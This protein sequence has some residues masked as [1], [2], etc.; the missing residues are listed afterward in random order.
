MNAFLLLLLLLPSAGLLAAGGTLAGRVLAQGEPLGGA[1]VVLVGE[2]KGAATDLNGG[3]LILDV[4]PGPHLLRVSYLGMHTWEQD[5]FMLSEYTTRIDVELMPQALQGDTLVVQARR[6]LSPLDATSSQAVL[7]RRE[8]ELS[9]RSDFLDLLATQAGVTRDEDGGMHLRGGRLGEVRVLLD[10]QDL[11]DPLDM[12]FQDLINEDM[13][14]ELVVVSGT[15]GAR[16]GDALSGVVR[17]TGQSRVRR[18]E[19]RL[20]YTSADLVDSPWRERGAY[21]VPE[22]GLWRET[23]HGDLFG[24]DPAWGRLNQPGRM[25]LKVAT[26]ARMSGVDMVLGL[27]S[28][29]QDSHLPHGGSSRGDLSLNLGHDMASGGRLELGLGRK[30]SL[31]QGYSHFWKYLPLNRHS[32]LREQQRLNLRFSNSLGDRSVYRL[33]LGLV[34]NE[35][36]RGILRD[37]EWLAES[38]YRRRSFSAQQDFFAE[39]H[40]PSLSR[41][42]STRG[43]IAGD[44]TWRPRPTFELAAGGELTRTELDWKERHL[45]FGDAE[46][47]DP[48]LSWTDASEHAP[49]QGALWSEQKIETGWLVLHTGLRL[50]WFDPDAGAWAE[51]D[52]LLQPDGG[53]APLQEVDPWLYLSPR[54]GIAFP[55]SER[56]VMHA[57][58]GRFIQFPDHRSLYTNSGRT[59]DGG[60]LPL[61][62]YAGLEPQQTTAFEIGAKQRPA[63]G[64]QLE[65]TAW[66]KDMKKLLS[67]IVGK[68]LTREYVVYANSDYGNVAG[69]DLAA[70]LPLGSRS[71]ARIDYTLMNA[72]GSASEPEAGLVTVQNG[73]EVEYNEFPLDF[74][75]RHDLSAAL[76]TDWG[77]GVSSSLLVQGASGLPYTPFIDVGV[78]APTNSANRPWTWTADLGLRWSRALGAHRMTLRL[79][80]RNLF[81]RRNVVQVFASSGEPYV[82]PRNL[83]GSTE[84]SKHDP[85]HVSPP[86][87]LRLGLELALWDKR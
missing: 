45:V 30:S 46:T 38:E 52:R 65:V 76:E 29:T 19:F 54:L 33:R 13:V 26:P 70:E 60:E 72:R 17:V 10:G 16:Y 82:D 4:S 34:R 37:G 51:P 73:E 55:V 50:D 9:P 12:G 78:T 58:Y 11:R 74:D 18:P 48:A 61:L 3:F 86:R 7:G 79:D 27:L 21:G 2:A 59:L 63:P 42:S 67:T 22:S 35:S 75:Q 5:I 84:D 28:E 64:V 57:S 87:S 77:L 66:M 25:Q 44:W 68:Q 69:V 85:S 31:R 36:R 80:V 8:L 62:G 71:R 14:S 20:R 49:L 23:D 32:Q 1:N 41:H 81:D 15:F 83:I 43:E 6:D 53:L 56:T 47:A 39:G 24:T 40:D